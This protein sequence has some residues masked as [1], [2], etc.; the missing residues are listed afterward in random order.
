M[1]TAFPQLSLEDAFTLQETRLFRQMLM[2]WSLLNNKVDAITR[3]L[4]KALPLFT[5]RGINGIIFN[6]S[7]NTH[8]LREN[9]KFHHLFTT[10]HQ[11]AFHQ[12]QEGLRASP[13][14]N[15]RGTACHSKWNQCVGKR[16]R[17]E[18]A[19]HRRDGV[20]GSCWN[21]EDPWL[22]GVSP[23]RPPRAYWDQSLSNSKQIAIFNALQI[24]SWF[25]YYWQSLIMPN[26]TAPEGFFP[27]MKDDSICAFIKWKTNPDGEPI[28][29]CSCNAVINWS[30]FVESV[31]QYQPIFSS[32]FIG[33]SATQPNSLLWRAVWQV[34][35]SFRKR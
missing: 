32:Y 14:W 35:G 16:S 9:A 30:D 26:E 4:S 7:V 34:Q 23:R 19:G 11:Q 22:D 13:W 2:I 3:F 12:R 10:F 18:A 20:E 25:S 24:A 8:L 1:N 33:A 6:I 28:I 21:G 17:N 31:C 29:N 15:W 27:S 5:T